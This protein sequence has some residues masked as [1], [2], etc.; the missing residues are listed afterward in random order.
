MTVLE[1]DNVELNFDNKSI[2]NAIY[3]KADKGKVTGILGSN[4]CG[5]TS[6]LRIIFGELIPNNKLIRV[7]KKPIIKPLYQKGFIKYL[8]QFSILPNSFSLKKGFDSF[9]VS[10]DSFLNDFPI[11]K[12]L[13]ENRFSQ[14]SGGERRLIETYIFIKSDAEIILL[15]EPFSHL[16][17]LYIEKIKEI[18]QIEK[19]NKIII[20]TDHLYKEILTISD[21]IYLLKNGWSRLIK[22]PEELIFYNYTNSL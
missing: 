9:H 14:F 21:E 10:L 6:L 19:E 13:K 22:N 11:F 4:G 18:I 15:D 5:K 20:I 3:F 7:D 2:L 8:P 17:P 16:A 12:N 1:I